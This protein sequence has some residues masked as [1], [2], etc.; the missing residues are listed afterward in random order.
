MRPATALLASARSTRQGAGNNSSRVPRL[1]PERHIRFVSSP[2]CRGRTMAALTAP[3]RK[4]LRRGGRES[5]TRSP[6]A[7][8]AS[9]RRTKTSARS[10]RRRRDSSVRGTAAHKCLK[11]S[12]LCRAP[13]TAS[14]VNK[15][16]NDD[17]AARAQPASGQQ[18]HVEL[19]P[20]LQGGRW[21][22]SWGACAA[23][24]WRWRSSTTPSCW[25]QVTCASVPFHTG[26]QQPLAR[27]HVPVHSAT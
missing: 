21:S 4:E 2:P 5:K 3:R 23:A 27:Y 1:P 26:S 18:A 19:V 16:R 20:P 24:P 22:C 8:S 6:A 15:S 10:R 12:L 7:L 17:L 25:R 11:H 14:T 13:T 9:C